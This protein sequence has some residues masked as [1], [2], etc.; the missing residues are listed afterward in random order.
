MSGKYNFK[1]LFLAFI[2]ENNKKM[3]KVGRKKFEL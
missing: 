2:R 1:K 3:K